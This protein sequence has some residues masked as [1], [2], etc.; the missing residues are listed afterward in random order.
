MS[1]DPFVSEI[2][3]VIKEELGIP[4]QNKG[5]WVSGITSFCK[6]KWIQITSRGSCKQNTESHM[7]K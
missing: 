7:Q 3:N 2:Q 1:F 6:A 5:G 4:V